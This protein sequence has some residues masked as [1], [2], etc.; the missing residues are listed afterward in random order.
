MAK[1]FVCDVQKSTWSEDPPGQNEMLEGGSSGQQLTNR[2][3]CSN[4]MRILT[5]TLK[6]QP[7]GK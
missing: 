4:L 6:P 5:G 7:E 2:E 1:Q 3:S